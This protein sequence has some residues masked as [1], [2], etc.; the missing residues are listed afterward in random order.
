M[1][2][3]VHGVS[4]ESQ[5]L[6]GPISMLLSRTNVAQ[7]CRGVSTEMSSAIRQLQSNWMSS[8][9]LLKSFITSSDGLHL[10]VSS[11]F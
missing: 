2:V 6:H 7:N 8:W 1:E 11:I 4:V 9:S 10:V 5:D 3:F